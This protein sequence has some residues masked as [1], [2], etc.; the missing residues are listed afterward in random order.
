MNRTATRKE[1]VLRALRASSGMR[2]SM[3]WVP[4]HYLTSPLI[5][6]SEGLRRLRELRA[7]GYR[8]EMRR[9]PLATRFYRIVE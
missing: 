2:D 7:D 9:G 8:I 1:L 3:G 4:G 6:G 5:G